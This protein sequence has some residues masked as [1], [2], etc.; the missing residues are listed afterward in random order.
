MNVLVVIALVKVLSIISPPT[1]DFVYPEVPRL[2]IDSMVETS[3]T[4]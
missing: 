1:P 4:F 2:K 3:A